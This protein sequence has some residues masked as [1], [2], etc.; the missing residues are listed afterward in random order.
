MKEEHWEE[1]EDGAKEFF[2]S[3]AVLQN[4]EVDEQS[5]KRMRKQRITELRRRA[6]ER[7]DWK[8]IAGEYDF[9]F[10]LDNVDDTADES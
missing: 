8:R 4:H 2:D 5:E 1:S 6:E 3:V 10:D 9:N 7:S